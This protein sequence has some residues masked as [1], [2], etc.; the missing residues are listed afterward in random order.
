MDVRPDEQSRVTLIRQGSEQVSRLCRKSTDNIEDAFDDVT[1]MVVLGMGANVKH[2]LFLY[3]AKYIDWSYMKE[4][5]EVD[6]RYCEQDDYD[7]LIEYREDN[8][9]GEFESDNKTRYFKVKNSYE[10]MGF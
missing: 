8:S 7:E 4:I 1:L 9:W 6:I 3:R 10:D 2:H 5:E